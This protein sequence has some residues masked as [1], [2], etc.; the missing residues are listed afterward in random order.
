MAKDDEAVHKMVKK[1]SR[2]HLE[3]ERTL[4]CSKAA[5]A[6]M[7]QAPIKTIEPTLI[8]IVNGLMHLEKWQRSIVEKACCTGQLKPL[9][10]IDSNR[11]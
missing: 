5:I 7:L 10:Y 3:I 6:L 2:F 8:T 1:V 9:L 4:H 11:F